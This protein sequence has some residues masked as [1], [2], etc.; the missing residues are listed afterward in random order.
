MNDEIEVDGRIRSWL[1][2]DVQGIPGWVLEATFE[3]TRR[4]R[5]QTGWRR[6]AARFQ[7]FPSLALTAG[8]A[9]LVVAIASLGLHANEPAV[10]SQPPASPSAEPSPTAT[11][12]PTS[13]SPAI[14]RL[15]Y[16][17]L[18][19]GWSSDG[20][21]LLIQKSDGNLFVL[22]ADGS[23]T[24]LTE[25]LSA[26]RD[27]PG[28]ARPRG[29]AISPDGSRVVFAGLTETGR[30]CHNG[31]LFVVDADG[32]PAE[33]L[34]KSH[35]PQNGIVRYPTFSPDGT[36]IAVVDDY[37]DSSH[38]VW[39]MNA[40]G[41]QAHKIVSDALGAGHVGG[42]T[43]LPAG[44]RIRLSSDLGYQTFAPDGSGFTGPTPRP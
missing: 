4:S 15:P 24:Q 26:L 30:S 7:F 36:R 23:E 27:I 43:W 13:T 10:G 35:L 1:E 11:A 37:C 44:D 42:L 41:S 22:H 5:Q 34:W 12:A 21:R 6:I 14:L 20:S 33:V 40:D 29:A 38:N 9:V 25:Q 2:A 31:A 3:R 28:S 8:V 39:V 19:L 18:A 16:D 32:G 17:G